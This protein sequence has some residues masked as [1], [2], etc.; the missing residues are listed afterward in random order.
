MINAH[1]LFTHDSEPSLTGKPTW[2]F[3]TVF[4]LG[5]RALSLIH[6]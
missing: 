1:D 3:N 6:I 4:R 2:D 5:I